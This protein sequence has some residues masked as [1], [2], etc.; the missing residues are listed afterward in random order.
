MLQER[1]GALI[2]PSAGLLLHVTKVIERSHQSTHRPAIQT[3]TPRESAKL[4]ESNKKVIQL[5][6][7]ENDRIHCEDF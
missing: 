5:F 7:N 6:Y 4:R 2:E 3:G 1:I